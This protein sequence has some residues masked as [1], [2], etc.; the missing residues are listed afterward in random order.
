M[1]AENPFSTRDDLMAHI[2]NAIFGVANP[3]FRWFITPLQ[4]RFISLIVWFATRLLLGV[5]TIDSVSGELNH[6]NPIDVISEITCPVLLM[7]GTA[8][9]LIP[10]TH[11][12]WLSAKAT[13][14]SVNELWLPIGA[15]HTALENS[16]TDEF[17]RRVITFI[18]THLTRTTT[19]TAT[20][21]ATATATVTVKK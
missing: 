3:L 20:A 1:V 6:P 5:K 15:E 21:T 16:H 7:H 8:D 2:V 12:Q 18:T 13:A 4:Q 19:T 11:S 9:Q 14:A 17:Y 10:Y